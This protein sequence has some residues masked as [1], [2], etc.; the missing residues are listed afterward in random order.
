MLFLMCSPNLAR[1]MCPQP[2]LSFQYGPNSARICSHKIALF[3][4]MGPRYNM[5]YVV[6]IHLLLGCSNS[7]GSIPH[8]IRSYSK[9]VASWQVL[10][11]Y[12]LMVIVGVAL[13]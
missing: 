5:A 3:L 9:L 11:N 13:I 6:T 8:G 12:K 7:V 1:H 4:G 10:C 2:M